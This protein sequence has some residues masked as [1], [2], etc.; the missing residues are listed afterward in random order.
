MAKHVKM[1]LE[2]PRESMDTFG[3]FQSRKISTALSGQGVPADNDIDA[4]LMA[5]VTAI[6]KDIQ[7]QTVNMPSRAPI[8]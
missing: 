1:H 2:E 3:K 4:K 7:G 6:L 5:S 8:H